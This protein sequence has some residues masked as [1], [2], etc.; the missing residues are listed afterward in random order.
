MSE[1]RY[2][3]PKTLADAVTLLAAAQ[4]RA[5]LLAGG[6]DLLIQMRAG[7]VAPELLVDVKDIRSWAKSPPRATAIASGRRSPPCA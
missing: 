2:A 3:A 7:R 1:M 4:G 5:R 6:T